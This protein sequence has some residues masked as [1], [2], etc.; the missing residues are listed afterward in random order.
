MV[1][2]AGDGNGAWGYAHNYASKS[3]A[4]RDALK[5]CG[6]SSCQTKVIANTQCLAYAH[7]QSGGYWYGIGMAAATAS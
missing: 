6:T 1:S 5:G 4:R 7:S 3:K 2:I